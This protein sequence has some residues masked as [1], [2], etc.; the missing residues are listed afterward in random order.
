ML[1]ECYVE[2]YECYDFLRPIDDSR[3]C[4]VD[5]DEQMMIT[6][7]A[8]LI[9]DMMMIECYLMIECCLD[10][11]QLMIIMNAISDDEY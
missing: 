4:Y 6:M 10:A 8:I 3:E 9:S 7:N 1:C 5:Y 2:F 11:K